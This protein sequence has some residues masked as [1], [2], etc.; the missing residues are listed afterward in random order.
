MKLMH[1][2][3]FFVETVDFLIEGFNSV[4]AEGKT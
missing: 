1:P 3:R 4:M 2:Q